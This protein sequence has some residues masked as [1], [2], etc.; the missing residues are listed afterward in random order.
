MNK[1]AITMLMA[2]LIAVFSFWGWHWYNITMNSFKGSNLIRLHIIAHSNDP[3]DQAL[4]YMVRDEVIRTMAP[5]FEGVESVEQAKAV[6]S[7]HAGDISMA[8]RRVLLKSGCSYPVT[9]CMGSY[10]F[11]D[12]SY[13]IERGGIPAELILPAGNYQAV[14]VI[15]GEGRGANWWCVLFPPLCFISQ[16]E[17]TDTAGEK[18]PSSFVPETSVP[19]AENS[20]NNKPGSISDNG[21]K[22]GKVTSLPVLSPDLSTGSGDGAVPSAVCQGEAPED[23]QPRVVFKFKFMEFVADSRDWLGSLFG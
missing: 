17:I 16:S 10:R 19:A 2:V 8:A 7:R 13:R 14:R 3:L 6:V 20:S 23:I 12:R 1:K 21:G 22:A 9:V 18:K 11:P 15:I 5:Y 4:K